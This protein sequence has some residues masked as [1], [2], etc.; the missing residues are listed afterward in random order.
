M[1]QMAVEGVGISAT[2]RIKQYT[3]NTVSRWRETAGKDAKRF[4]ERML[5]GFELLE[6]QADEIRSF[7][8][9]K[10]NVV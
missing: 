3:P 2:A 5:S 1:A 9:T 6:L 7:V 10:T 4:N 8:N